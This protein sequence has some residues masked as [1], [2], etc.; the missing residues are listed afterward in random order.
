MSTKCPFGRNQRDATLEIL[1]SSGTEL[2]IL[3]T[4]L[5]ILGRQFQNE[6]TVR[7]NILASCMVILYTHPYPYVINLLLW[8]VLMLLCFVARHDRHGALAELP[9]GITRR[10][11]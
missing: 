11:A 3:G 4:E 1:R 7:W 5:P 9:A 10:A 2:P 8:A 6:R